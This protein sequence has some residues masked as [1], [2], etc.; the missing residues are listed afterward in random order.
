MKRREVIEPVHVE[1]IPTNLKDGILYISHRYSTAAHL[2]CCGC[3]M[4]VVTPL[5]KAKWQLAETRGT[6]SLRPSI[7]NW[8]FACQ[9]HYWIDHNRVIWATTMSREQIDRVKQK[10]LIAVSRGIPERKSDRKWSELV[11]KFFGAG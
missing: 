9:S 2:C 3:S 11:Q 10:D 5:N 8:S 1:I 6:V 7:G 4:E